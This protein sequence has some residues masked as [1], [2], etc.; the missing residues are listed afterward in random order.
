VI[1]LDAPAWLTV[2]AAT[3]PDALEL[4]YFAGSMHWKVR[5]EGLVMKVAMDSPREHYLARL[6]MMIGRGAVAI[7]ED[8]VSAAAPVAVPIHDHEPGHAHGHGHTHSHGH[9]HPHDHGHHP[10]H[11]RTARRIV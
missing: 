10:D 9:D 5:F 11:G 6:S 4:G 2:Q 7:G 3:G 1:R 8:T